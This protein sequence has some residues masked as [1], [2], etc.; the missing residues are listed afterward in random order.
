MH[1][2]GWQILEERGSEVED[3]VLLGMLVTVQS[4]LLLRPSL[5]RELGPSGP[6]GPGLVKFTY[7]E[8]LLFP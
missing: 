7:C 6:D 8:Y 2:C 4:I 5:R 3:R 1:R